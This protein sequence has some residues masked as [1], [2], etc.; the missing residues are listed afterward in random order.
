VGIGTS[1]PSARLDVLGD[2]RTT[3]MYTRELLD[4][5]NNA[6]YLNPDSLS[7]LNNLS[8]IR[9]RTESL[10]MT[11]GAADGHVLQSDGAGNASWV[12][13]ASLA[14]TETDPLS[15]ALTGNAGTDPANDFIGTTDAQ[16]LKFRVNDNPAGEITT[17][18]FNTAFGLNALPSNTGNRNTAHG[19]QALH[20]NG[21]GSG[22][23]ASGVNALRAN[24]T[25]NNNTASGFGALAS[26]ETGS[27]NTAVG[28]SALVSNDSGR[29]NTALGSFADVSSGNLTNATAIGFNAMVD[30]SNK[31]RLGNANVTVIEGQVPFTSVSDGRFKFNVKEDV[32]GL[33]FISNLRP[34]TYQ[35]DAQAQKDFVDGKLSAD[36]LSSRIRSDKDK[37][38]F[39]RM[40]GF[41]AQEVEAA[42]GKAGFDF[43]GVKVPE[44]ERQY[45]TLSY[46]SFVVPL[47]KA[48]Q[49]QQ[50]QIE[51]Q[52]EHIDRLTRENQDL[53]Q[54]ASKI[55]ALERFIY[56]A[57][58]NK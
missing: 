55:E 9:L 36:E 46:S 10:R 21:A 35:F 27:S 6:F 4:T 12:D 15:W 50:R 51:A 14:I 52:Q 38:G 54:L 1:T 44:S 17:S 29:N 13:P 56:Q 41:I 18:D 25:G 32:A 31:I 40:T 8:L 23:T 24:E 26:N 28:V 7:E 30:A 22:N 47:V 16:P 48:M 33:D 49:E 5:D 37:D 2:I 39:R 19:F 11:D 45:Y 3:A 43:D 20:I 53:K 34:V 57:S 42:A 58:V